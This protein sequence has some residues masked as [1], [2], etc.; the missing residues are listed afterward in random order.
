MY[1]LHYFRIIRRDSALAGLN[2]PSQVLA[3]CEIFSRSE[4]K[5][6]A[7]VLGGCQQ[8]EIG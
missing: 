4:F 6:S 3:H 2:V 1:W 5:V 8:Q 7:V